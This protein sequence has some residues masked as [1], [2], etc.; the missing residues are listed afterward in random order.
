MYKR[1]YPTYPK[2]SFTP[3]FVNAKTGMPCGTTSAD[4]L[5]ALLI[6]GRGLIGDLRELVEELEERLG[7]DMEGTYRSG[8]V[9]V[10]R[11]ASF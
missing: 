3:T 5:R 7:A 4:E 6:E 2:K 10:L 11:K 9:F 1:S 8:F